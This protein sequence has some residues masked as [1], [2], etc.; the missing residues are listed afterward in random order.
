MF[1]RMFGRS[2]K[3]HK[4]AETPEDGKEDDFVVVPPPGESSSP[5]FYVK[6]YRP[7]PTPPDSGSLYTLSGATAFGGDR[8]S[9]VPASQTEYIDGVPFKLTVSEKGDAESR[10]MTD[11]LACTA[12]LQAINWDAMEYDFRVEQSVL[13]NAG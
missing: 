11:A 13:D 4:N 6:E 12:R 5:R 2:N 9:S 3:H 10:E 1:T 7:A 8:R